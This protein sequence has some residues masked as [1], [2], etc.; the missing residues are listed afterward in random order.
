[1]ARLE[2]DGASAIVTGASRG[3]GPYIAAALAQRG[4]RVALVARSQADLDANVRALSDAGGEVMAVV[5]DVTA[6]EDRRSLLATVE[7]ELGP[8]DLLVNNAGGD[9]Q[10]RFHD[11][12]E[13]EIE[14]VLALNL[15]SAVILTRLV[16]PGMLARE[17]GHIVNISSMAGRT[18]FPYTEAYAAAK[19]GLIALTRV[20]RS[21]YRHCGVSASTLILG[22]VGEA[23]VG[24]RT[25]QEIGIKLPPV[26]LVSPDRVGRPTVRAISRNKAELVVLP[27]PGRMIRAVMDRF[28]GL[29]PAINRAT[30]AEKTMQT[31]SDYRDRQVQLTET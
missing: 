30:G 22:P 4:V 1:M 9:P 25:A 20:L 15:A 6:R 5:A 10:R 8:V 11:L 26:G 2:L 21:D 16:L 24:A 29:G 18:G 23:G 3:I 17:R 27:G 12:S 7:R 13:D 31:V 28:P 14:R 19:D